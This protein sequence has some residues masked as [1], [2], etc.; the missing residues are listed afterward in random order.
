M[1]YHRINNLLVLSATLMIAPFL[2]GCRGNL[3]CNFLSNVMSD[4]QVRPTDARTIRI[5]C[6]ECYWWVDSDNR[7]N[8]AGKGVAKFPFNPLYDQEINVS[9]VL[10]APSQGVGKN[11]TLYPNNVRGFIKSGGNLY[12]FRGAHGILGIENMTSGAVRGAY[13]SSIGLSQAKILGG[14]SQAAPYFIFGTFTAVPDRDHRGPGIRGRTEGD[15]YERK[16]PP[17]KSA[18]PSTQ[19]MTRN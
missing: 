14:W 17:L 16:L 18:S 9:F 7:F 4:I 1:R 6:Q 12:R 15:G 11:Y 10:D 2:G 8:I 3:H 5:D 19:P 13:R